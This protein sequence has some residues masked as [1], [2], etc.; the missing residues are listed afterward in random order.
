MRSF[1][2]IFKYRLLSFFNRIK[3]LDRWQKIKNSVFTFTIFTLLTFLYLGFLRILNYL[4]S[5]D[6]I[7]L[8][9]VW[10]L[11]AMVF[12]LNFFMIAVSSFIISVTTLFYSY[13]LKFLV[14]LP[15]SVKAILFEKFLLSVFYSSWSLAVIMIPYAFA[16]IK[17]MSLPFSFFVA[18]IIM[19]IPYSFLASY[20]GIIFSITLMS[21][22]PSPRTRD[23]V[24]LS[25]SFSF[26]FVY[27]ALRFSKPEQLLK[28]D[29]FGLIVNYLSY[30]Q[31][32]TAPYLPS[33]W[34]TK[35]LMKF[36]SGDYQS[37]FI[38]CIVQYCFFILTGWAIVKYGSEIYL[39][40]LS[41]AQ[42][43]PLKKIKFKR[44]FEII[45]ARR[46]KR[47]KN[48]MMLVFKERKS[49]IRDVKYY[50]QTIL[51]LALS[52]V[53]VFSIKNIPVD[54][55]DAK[56][57]IA[58]INIVISGF[59]ISALALRFAFTSVSLENGSVWILKTISLKSSEFIYAKLIFYF[60]YILIFDFIIVGVSNYY[61][62][63][64][65]IIFKFS[66]FVSVIMSFFIT[67]LA[68]AMGAIFP[69]F[70]TLNIHQVESSYGGF[71][72][73]SASIFYTVMTAV[74]FVYPVKMYFASKYL[75]DGYFDELFFYSSILI[76][77]IASFAIIYLIL[78][79]SVKKFEVMEV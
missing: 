29:A 21:L 54:G 55:Q 16:M 38:Y 61:L 49:F 64:D 40:A 76:F 33:W 5:I 57:F 35:T 27:M 69:D 1:E 2:I 59:V 60:I 46:F 73:M 15:V 79:K 68:V 14:P 43:N 25:S 26:A 51:V 67:A 23:F 12:L 30:L 42:N 62:T 45:I 19:V 65:I 50:S 24:W 4:I 53:Y 47:L 48:I 37:F 10:K 6:V 52:M 13:D 72:F 17:S 74:W 34:F 71:L 28:P 8:I 56:N 58:F 66:V 31:A 7:G 36:A 77:V 3:N 41:G 75:K 63:A 39:V 9:L 18:F 70:N 11:S 20:I 32:P 78:R 22:F 44:T